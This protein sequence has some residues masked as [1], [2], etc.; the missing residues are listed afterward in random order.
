MEKYL[1]LSLSYTDAIDK[2]YMKMIIML[3]YHLT[4]R[5]YTYDE[6]HFARN[7]PY[8]ERHVLLVPQFWYFFGTRRRFGIPGIIITVL[9][10]AALISGLVQGKVDGSFLGGFLVILAVGVIARIIG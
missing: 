6:P 3:F 2:K 7:K 8:A 9:A 10:I 5:L 4:L 1:I